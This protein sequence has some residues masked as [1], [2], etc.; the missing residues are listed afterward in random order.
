[1][2]TD[3]KKSG[4]KKNK[5]CFNVL[6]TLLLVGKDA[7]AGVQRHIVRAIDNLTSNSK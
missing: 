5:D 6:P 7:K 1:M 4:E 3:N 2:L